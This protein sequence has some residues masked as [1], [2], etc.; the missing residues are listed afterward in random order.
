LRRYD[1]GKLH[2]ENRFDFDDRLHEKEVSPHDELSD[3]SPEE[4]ERLRRQL[5]VDQ[6][7]EARIQL[8]R[9]IAEKKRR[10]TTR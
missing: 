6:R 5:V 8:E 1:R 7:P 9:V 3:R 4:L 10:Q 2:G